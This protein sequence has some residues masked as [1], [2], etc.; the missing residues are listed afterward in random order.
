MKNLIFI[1]ILLSC[2]TPETKYGP[3]T[4][5]GLGLSIKKSNL[6]QESHFKG[7]QNTSSA[8]ARNYANLGAIDYCY[9]QKKVAFISE[10]ID[11]SKRRQYNTLRSRVNYVRNP[12]Y[13]YGAGVYYDSLSYNSYHRHHFGYRNPYGI[14]LFI[15][16]RTYY[17][18]SVRIQFPHFISKFICVDNYKSLEAD[19]EFEPIAKELVSTFTND[20]KGGLLVK[21]S[22]HPE[23]KVGDLLLNINNSR[24]ENKD[25]LYGLGLKDTTSNSI[26]AKVI[27]NKTIQTIS[28][29]S[30]DITDHIKKTNS[31]IVKN[32]CKKIDSKNVNYPTI[33]TVK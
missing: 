9:S 22:N 23:L 29:N 32:T 21:K 24:I 12:Y 6:W 4:D 5:D 20:F 14:S 28:V 7:N 19:I 16:L 15:P 17:S 27:R 1:F 18:H 10:T 31:E 25:E 3:T 8:T 13:D 2:A 33:C 30:K 26:V 11:K